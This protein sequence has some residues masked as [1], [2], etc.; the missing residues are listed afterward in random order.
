MEKGRKDNKEAGKTRRSS[1]S[2]ASI[3]QAIGCAL[4]LGREAIS[5]EP[6]QVAN[7]GET[8]HCQQGDNSRR[9]SRVKQWK[10]SKGRIQPNRR[11]FLC[12]LLKL[13]LLT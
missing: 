13:S 6:I 12:R 10:Y 2:S 9:R 3:D 11:L 7:L 1:W 4:L 5:G 8:G